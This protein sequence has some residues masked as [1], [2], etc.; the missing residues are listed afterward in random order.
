MTVV[1]TESA[2]TAFVS[3]QGRRAEM[4]DTHIL[5]PDFIHTGW[6][7]GGVFDGHAGSFAAEYTAERLPELFGEALEKG[8]SAPEAFTSA[9]QEVSRRLEVQQSGTTAATFLLRAEDIVTANVGDSRILLVRRDELLQL[10][11]DHRLD[12]PEE[13]RRIQAA[14]GQ[15]DYPYSCKEYRCLMP[16]RTIGDI[17]FKDIGVVPLPSTRTVARTPNDRMLIVGCDGLFDFMSNAEVATAADR[18]HDPEELVRYLA[19]E[20][21]SIRGGTDNLTVLAVDLTD[22]PGQ[23]G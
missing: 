11:R 10:T 14:G 12:D 13:L 20:V 23:A 17:F 18:F 3:R 2:R 19:R 8:M 22:F 6:L 21:L 9:Y 16:T 1:Q 7:F 15:I 4:E 5:I